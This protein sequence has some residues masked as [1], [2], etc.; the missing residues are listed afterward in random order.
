[1]NIKDSKGL[2]PLHLSVKSAK[3]HRSSKGIKQLLIKGADRNALDNEGKRPID[4]MLLP[5]D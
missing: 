2:T 1:M 3:D 5:T 4:Y